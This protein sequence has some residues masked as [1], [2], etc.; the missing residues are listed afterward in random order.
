MSSNGVEMVFELYGQKNIPKESTS[1]KV[2]LKD[3]KIK[4]KNDEEVIIFNVGNI[5]IKI[6]NI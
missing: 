3:A 2:S 5:N 6:N 1:D 4:L